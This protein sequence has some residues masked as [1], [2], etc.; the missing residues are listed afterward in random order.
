MN[1]LDRIIAHKREVVA[2]RKRVSPDPI[3]TAQQRIPR[4][5]GGVLRKKN[6]ISVIAEFKKASP[7]KGVIRDDVEPVDVAHTYETNG[8][9]AMSVLTNFHP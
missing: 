4:P 9:S 7:S 3:A 6:R 1:I 2:E 8:A 5:F